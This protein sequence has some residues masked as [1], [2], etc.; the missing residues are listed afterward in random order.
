MNMIQVEAASCE[1]KI[2]NLSIK[3]KDYEREI[4]KVKHDEKM[5]ELE[6]M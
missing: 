5:E 2:Y 3:I 6:K 4:V 1:S